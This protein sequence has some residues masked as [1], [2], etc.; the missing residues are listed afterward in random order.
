MRWR[1]LHRAFAS[2]LSK[3]YS[4]WHVAS[5]KS[6]GLLFFFFWKWRALV[7][8]IQHENCRRIVFVSAERLLLGWIVEGRIWDDDAKSYIKWALS[9]RTSISFVVVL[10]PLE[11]PDVQACAEHYQQTVSLDGA[12]RWASITRLP[13]EG[14]DWPQLSPLKHLEWVSFGMKEEYQR[15]VENRKELAERI[16]GFWKRNCLLLGSIW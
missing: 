10:F 6:L 1:A 14:D 5:Q 3:S 4:L 15:G 13:P 11:T 12:S 9:N 2:Q 16:I 7:S 8:L